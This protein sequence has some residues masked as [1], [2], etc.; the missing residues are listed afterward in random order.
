MKP[1]KGLNG[2][3]W[4]LTNNNI[5]GFV[6]LHRKILDWEWYDDPKTFKLFMHLILTVNIKSSTWHGIE[7]P[8]GSRVFSYRK[9]ANELLFTEREIRTHLNRLIKTHTVTQYSTPNYSV[10]TVVNWD[11]YQF[12]RHSERQT[13]DTQSDTRPTQ[14]RHTTDNRIRI[15]KNIRS[16]EDKEEYARA[17]E[18]PLSEPT[19]EEI[20]LA[21]EREKK[22]RLR[23]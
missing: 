10:I 9:L 8:A 21:E 19:F 12:N 13:N 4:I 16:K 17:R 1:K 14:Q 2:V 3:I 18:N 5:A 15:Y 7:I 22:R 6:K 20:V 23:E 11:L